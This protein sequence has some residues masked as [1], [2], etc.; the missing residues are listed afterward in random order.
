MNLARQIEFVH[1]LI[2]QS[3]N[4]ERP[5]PE[6]SSLVWKERGDILIDE[7]GVTTQ[8]LKLLVI[9]QLGPKWKSGPSQV[10]GGGPP[11]PGLGQEGSPCL[12]QFG[13]PMIWGSSQ[14]FGAGRVIYTRRYF[15]CVK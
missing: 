1:F 12:G 14:A 11:S 7:K 13:V 15:L 9:H 5:S 8:S 6:W 2:I 3:S 10:P 4:T